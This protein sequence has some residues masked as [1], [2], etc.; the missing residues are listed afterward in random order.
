MAISIQI[1]DAGKAGGVVNWFPLFMGE[2]GMSDKR[3]EDVR[4]ELRKLEDEAQQSEAE[5]SLVDALDESSESTPETA[6]SH[7][8]AD[9]MVVGVA[10][11]TTIFFCVSVMTPHQPATRSRV[12]EQEERRA[13]LEKALAEQQSYQADVLVVESAPEEP[14]PELE[15][16]P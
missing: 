12:T 4:D 5:E 7:A 3:P 1:S 8:L 10:C 9:I 16:R 15:S 13:E 6:P 11:L 14:L 2:K